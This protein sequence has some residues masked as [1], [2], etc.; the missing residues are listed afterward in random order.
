S[1]DLHLAFRLHAAGDQKQLDAFA[2]HLRPGAPW[3]SRRKAGLEV[4]LVNTT[5]LAVHPPMNEGAVDRVGLANGWFGR[6]L[7][8]EPEPGAC[9]VVRLI[10]QPGLECRSIGKSQQWKLIAHHS[11]KPKYEARLGNQDLSE[12]PLMTVENCQITRVGTHHETFLTPWGWDVVAN[13]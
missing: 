7:L 11:S 6:A 13:S 1:I 10:R 4:I 8:G 5:E 2:I 9:R 12:G 3:P